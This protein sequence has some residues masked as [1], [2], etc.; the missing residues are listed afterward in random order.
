MQTADSNIVAPESLDLKQLAL[1]GQGRTADVFLFRDRFVI[2]VFRP[3]FPKQAIDNE[4]LVCRSIGSV[5]DIP[6]AYQRLVVAGRDAIIFD[7]TKGESGFR[8]LFRNPWNITGF[9]REFAAI[10]AR[11]H[12]T[13]VPD[14]V[15][16]LK[17]ILVRNIN[18]HDHLTTETKT[19]IIKYLDRLPGGNKLC[20]G[21]FHPENILMGGGKPFVL[22]WMTATRGNPLADVA[23]TSILLKWAPGLLPS[24]RFCSAA[25]EGS[26]TDIT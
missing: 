7:F 14:E 8:H 2:K 22:D 20:H 4:Y 23:R 6:K 3:N 17:S 11:I 26:S 12:L 19:K 10:H 18:L 25:S 1:L 24:S 15:P 5:V 16:E 9:A 21:D 13:S